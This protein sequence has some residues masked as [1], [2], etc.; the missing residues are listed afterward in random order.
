MKRY[1]LFSLVCMLLFPFVG[2]NQQCSPYSSEEHI[3]LFPAKSGDKWGYIDTTGKFV[4]NPQFDEARLF[5]EGLAAVEIG[6]KWGEIDKTGKI[7]INPV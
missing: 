4:I 1:W 7:V 5:Q 3:G 6:G 2:C